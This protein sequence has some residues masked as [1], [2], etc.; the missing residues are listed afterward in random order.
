MGGEVEAVQLHPVGNPR[1]G[2]M[3][4]ERAGEPTMAG[5]TVVYPW[6]LRLDDG[7]YV[8]RVLPVLAA[9]SVPREG[10]QFV[11]TDIL[12][13]EA[14]W[15][16]QL[17]YAKTPLTTVAGSERRGHHRPQLVADL[18]LQL[19]G[20]GPEGWTVA[21]VAR[22]RRPGAERR[23]SKVAI[24]PSADA[25]PGSYE[26][27]PPFHATGP[28]TEF[29]AVLP[30]TVLTRWRHYRVRSPGSRRPPNRAR[31]RNAS[32]RHLREAET[33][34][35]TIATLRDP[36]RGYAVAAAGAEHDVLEEGTI[37]WMSRR[38]HARGRGVGIF[39]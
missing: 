4:V 26:V 23:S 25:R 2:T 12:R 14:N 35:A 15:P 3:S 31:I 29:V 36:L 39:T 10:R 17:I 34:T 1:A 20:V 38:G 9:A 13:L 30:V 8:R 18:R 16:Y 21:P 7:D 22:Y 19:S 37:L 5:D 11:V 24:K 6:R 32:V 33:I 28:S 27:A